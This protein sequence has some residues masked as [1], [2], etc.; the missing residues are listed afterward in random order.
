MH[1]LLTETLGLAGVI[2]LLCPWLLSMLSTAIILAIKSRTNNNSTELKSKLQKE[3][4]YGNEFL[5]VR[6]KYSA[7]Q[8]E[9]TLEVFNELL[10]YIQ[11]LREKLKP[12][13]T[14]VGHDY[15]NLL[16]DPNIKRILLKI[17]QLYWNH[18]TTFTEEDRI[19]V[20]DLKNKCQDLSTWYFHVPQ[21]TE[22]TFPYYFEKAFDLYKEL[23]NLQTRI[24]N[25][26]ARQREEY[27]RFLAYNSARD[28]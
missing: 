4:D 18:Q 26:A 15:Y 16:K 7:R 21:I 27:E 3:N 6:L 20:H 28:N 11:M 8:T 1:L 12:V 2:Q 24:R 10:L 23:T 13:A 17:Q 22:S 9:I 19:Y 25:S 14:E 5:K